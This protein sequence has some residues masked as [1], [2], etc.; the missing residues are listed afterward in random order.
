MEQGVKAKNIS[1]IGDSAGGGLVMALLQTL[2]EEKIDFPSSAILISPWTDLTLSG[3]SIKTRADRDPMLQPGKEMDAVVKAYI[4][5]LKLM[6][7]L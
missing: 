5:V 7:L 1:L 3:D 6:H 2:S 4:V